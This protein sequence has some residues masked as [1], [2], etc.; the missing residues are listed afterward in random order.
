MVIHM[1]LILYICFCLF[2]ACY[3]QVNGCEQSQ[4][5]ATTKS[6]RKKT[7][8]ANARYWCHFPHGLHHST[9]SIAV[10]KGTEV[11]DSAICKRSSCGLPTKNDAGQPCTFMQSAPPRERS[12]SKEY[13]C[14]RMPNFRIRADHGLR[15][16]LWLRSAQ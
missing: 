8:M 5:V 14:G 4:A 13:K 15:A 1:I 16:M 3:L 9:S 2:R 7:V 6:N 10:A 12:F 11:P